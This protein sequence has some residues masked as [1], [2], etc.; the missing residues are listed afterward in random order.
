MRIVVFGGTGS[1]G[2][3]VIDAALAAGHQVVAVARRPDAITVK[4]DHL[5]VVK[6]D[7]LQPDSYAPSIAGADAVISCIGPVGLTTPGTLLSDGIP[8]LVRAIEGAGVKRFVYES[9]LIA[10]DGAELGAGW[11]MVLKLGHVALGPLYR[12][13]VKAEAAILGST[14]DWVIVRPPGLGH[15]PASNAY[16]VGEGLAVNMGK[17]LAHADVA[18]FLVKAAADPQW[19]RKTVNIGH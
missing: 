12:E 8:L 3:N 10:S 11:R 9:G 15:A 19:A 6:G 17:T 5:T 1:T 7:V 2:K 14:L 18:D 13:K 4:H 16:K